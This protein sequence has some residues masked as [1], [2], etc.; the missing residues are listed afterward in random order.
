M[1]RFKIAAMLILLLTITGCAAE[2]SN[3]NDA[4]E[5]SPK[6][7]VG[8]KDSSL[9]APSMPVEELE[10]ADEQSPAAEALTQ[11]EED[12]SVTSLPDEENMVPAA[13]NEDTFQLNLTRDFG[14][15]V[16][17]S[18]SVE[19]KS[20]YSLL[21]YMQEE[22]Q[23]TTGFGGGFIKDINGLKSAA[24]SGDRYDWFYYVNGEVSPVGAGQV[25][26]H[27][28]DVIYWDYHLWTSGS[29]SVEANESFPPGE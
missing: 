11:G 17:D 18:R 23:V 10:Q 19:I 29:G 26:P 14:G 3:S 15:E 20:D 22:W 28:G 13:V 8:Q 7:T 6:Q 27:A 24:N 12:N 9:P 25:K 21:E 16:L 2:R 4:G 5:T 1:K